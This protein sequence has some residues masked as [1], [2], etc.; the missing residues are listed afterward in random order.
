[1]IKESNEALPEKIS[2]VDEIYM[3]D[4]DANLLRSFGKAL[5]ESLNESPMLRKVIKIKALEQFN[6][7]YDVLYQLIKNEKVEN[8]LS[9]R[10][11]LLKHFESEETLAQIEAKHPTL[12]FF[13]PKLPENSFSAEIWNTDEQIPAVAIR[14]KHRN[15]PVIGAYGFVDANSDEFV[16]EAGYIPAFPVIVIKDNE[17]VRVAQNRMQTQSA[18]PNKAGSDFEFEFTDECFDGS[19]EENVLQ[20]AV[21]VGEIDKK[22]I[23]AYN[24]Y[25]DFNGWHRDFIYYGLTPRDTV[26]PFIYNYEEKITSFKF[27]PTEDPYR[28]LKVISD[29]TDD[30]SFISGIT[31]AYPWTD[32]IFEFKVDVSVAR[33]NHP[34]ITLTKKFTAYPDELFEVTYRKFLWFY[35]FTITGFKEKPLDLPL[36]SWDL[37]DFSTAMKISIAEE[38]PSGQKQ[39]TYESTVKFAGNVSQDFKFGLKFGVSAERTDRVVITRTRQEGNDELGEPWVKFGDRIILSVDKIPIYPPTPPI[40]TPP[41]IPFTTQSLIRQPGPMDYILR[42][43]LREYN[44]GLCAFTVV[45]VAYTPR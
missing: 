31:K 21:S 28:I 19:K 39:E 33:R 16:V 37:N 26:G 6:K 43:N 40:I 18:V 4:P 24:I 23:E 32:G 13:V 35:I 11:L 36:M 15:T 3:S 9:V 20:K 44:T 7:D 27:S 8:G 42:Y 25:Q 1:L 41:I 12:T 45:P 5:Y 30:P 10:K 34:E 29:D 14:A 38:D 17:R 22:I 2:A